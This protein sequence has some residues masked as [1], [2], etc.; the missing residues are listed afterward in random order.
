M[1]SVVNTDP[2]KTTSF[3]PDI[4]KYFDSII[5]KCLEKDPADRFQSILDITKN[6]KSPIPV[7]IE[8]PETERSIVVL[9]FENMSSDPEQE[10]F[11]DGLT[12]EIITD[13]SHIHDLR[14][15]SRNSSM[16]LKGS[17]K[18]TK[19]IAS[20]LNV[21]YVL[22][23][24]VRKAGN[25]LRITA[26]LINAPI[27]DHVWAEKYDGTLDDIFDIQEKVSRS[28]V[29]ALKVKL[30]QKESKQLT[31]RP[32]D[33]IKAYEFYLKA[34][35]E[36]NKY[37]ENAIKIGQQ[38][39]Q[40]A[41]D[42]IGDNATLYSAMG[43]SYNCLSDINIDQDKNLPLAES[44]TNKA[45][46]IDPD[47]PGAH[48]VLGWI[49]WMFKG[50]LS[51]TFYHFKKALRANPNETVA[52]LGVA[53]VSA[54]I[55][56]I[57]E[58]KR[59]SERLTKIDPLDFL[60][61]V[62]P[63]FIH[64][65][66]GKYEIA[67]DYWK[68]FIK[69]FPNYPVIQLFHAMTLIY[70]DKTDE[71]QSV[72]DKSLI[73][74]PDHGYLRMGQFMLFA[75]TGQKEKA[76]QMISPGTKIRQYCWRICDWSAHVSIFLSYMG[77]KEEAMEWLENA[78][79]KGL[80]NYPYLSSKDPF[81]ENIRSEPRFKKLMKRVK[82]E[83]ENF[84]SENPQPY[85]EEEETEPLENLEKS[86]IV[87]PF[88]DMSPDKDNEYFSDGLTEE[89][90]TDLSHI[91]DLL[92]ISRSSAMTFKGTKQ[93]IPEIVKKV[94]VRY[95][96]EG[97]VRK[98]GNNLRITAQ[99]IDAT[100]D[101]HLWAEKYSG[102]L[103]DVF[104]IQEKV[105]RSIVEEL[106]VKLSP[107][108]NKQ[109]AERPIDN[110]QAYECYLR[111]MKELERASEEGSYKA[112]RNLQMGLDI[113]GDNVLLFAGM[114][115]VY[116]NLYE[117]GI[118]VTEETLIKAEEYAIKVLRLEP[119]SS[120]SYSLLGRIERFRGSALKA[121]RHFK[122]ALD[123][124]PNDREALNWLGLE[125]GWHV[126]R[127]DLA[128]PFIEKFID[129]DPLS[130][131]SHLISGI[132]Y[133]AACEFD[134]AL[135]SLNHMLKLEPGSIL[136]NCWIAHVL[137]WIKQYEKAYA[138]IDNMAQEESSE[139]MHKVFTGWLLFLKHALKGEKSK[140]LEFLSE[141]VRNFFWHDTDLP[142]L[143][144]GGFAII[145]E[146]DEALRWL[147]HAINKGNINYPLLSEKD[148]FLENIRGEE[149][150]KKLMVRVKYEWENFEV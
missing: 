74:N 90:I 63:G 149:R 9:P 58:A 103:D 3:R 66:D 82:H 117:I 99:L 49:S 5:G 17:R 122:Q 11:S 105:S 127:P 142:L 107:K 128:K 48:A 86:I 12:E 43:W 50:K 24:S 97:S 18:E 28:I 94:N 138:L 89:I 76:L 10:Y 108:E 36:I 79:N 92:V 148:P 34:S 102:T 110:I 64:F 118:S 115:L 133:W 53:C 25:N 6:I 40:N 101:A 132:N 119:N 31:E 106:K 85:I 55:G 23:G 131:R 67:H 38:Y 71:A 59:Y 77:L 27:D 73:E 60:S 93:T 39:I 130:P 81:L 21:Q 141:D 7:I 96:L 47:Y 75:K 1:Y 69:M 109:I 98:A 51:D 104:D 46:S 57:D 91:H 114:G 30:T 2:E 19:T 135:N 32:I 116:C 80:I 70:L 147:E 35:A 123:I 29:D 68:D 112:L 140:A 33:D 145:D 120:L 139:Q 125:Y 134:N 13:L 136:A 88:D 16:M 121:L 146:K 72:I 95:V 22:E 26:Q 54:M 126:G 113:I 20:E 137:I 144:A 65:W 14:V 61:I 87:L 41:L 52:I 62:L 44:Y 78:V 129:R 15:I 45:I 150:F 4:P 42:I 83:W 143:G 100:T 37:N 56:K 84:D 8:E 111:A 124:D